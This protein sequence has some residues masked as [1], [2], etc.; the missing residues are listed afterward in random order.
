MALIFE[1]L[2]G[3][4]PK[5]T[6][7]LRE[8]AE[9]T[10][11]GTKLIVLAV[12][13]APHRTDVVVEWERT[14]DPVTCAPDSR[15]L[16]HSNRAPLENGL[17]ADLLIGTTG[18]DAAAMSRRAFHVSHTATGAVDMITFPS[19]PKEADSAE[20][21]VREG[22]NA[23]HVPFSLVLGGPSALPLAV[24]VSRDGVVIRATAVSRYG[25]ELIV[26]L[27]VEGEQQIR[28]VGAPIP[29]PPTFFVDS[30]A[31]GIARRAEMKRH[32]GEHARP[33][34]LQDEAGVRHEEVRRLFSQEP[35]QTAPGQPFTSRFSVVFEAPGTDVKRG[36]LVIPFVELNDF[37]PSATA[38]LRELPVEVAMGGHR[39]QVVALEPH[40]PDERKIVLELP[41]SPTAPRFMQPARIYGSGPTF[42]FER[43]ALDAELPGR[44]AI[45]M[46]TNLGDPPIVTFSGVVL[47]IDGPVRLD[48]PLS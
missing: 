9:T 39:F 13:A 8:R 40:G 14:G 28:Q 33:I 42:G 27:E 21:R 32:F 29:I 17:A 36:T 45:W 46:A 34:T 16:V 11:D 22:R 25:G 24:E 3:F 47:R 31:D 4:R 6:R 41:P 12:A 5:E 38:D 10:E 44:D 2:I 37:A 35:Q 30:E 19:L 1:P 18:M 26:E 15:I 43:H 23:W 48:L 20:L 7:T